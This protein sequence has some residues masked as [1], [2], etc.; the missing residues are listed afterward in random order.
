MYTPI[1]VT[2]VLLKNKK[3]GLQKFAKGW[4]KGKEGKV[5]KKEAK[6][7]AAWMLDMYE[8]YLEQTGK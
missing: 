5:H 3:P 4:F 8:A 1:L 6:Q 7:D 2:S